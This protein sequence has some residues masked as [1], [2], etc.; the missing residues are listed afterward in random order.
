MS[1]TSVNS[2]SPKPRVASAGVPMRRP[3]VTHGGRG[4]NGTALRLTVMPASCRRSSACWPSRSECAQVDEHQ[5]HVGAAGEHG[6]AGRGDVR[7]GE[8]L[9]DDAGAVER[10][11]LAVLELLACAATLNATALAAITCM[12]GPPCWPGEHRRVDLLGVLLVG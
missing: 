9:G 5:V 6:D 12:S 3:E 4:S 8:P 11:L 1:A 2:T 10:A 7:R